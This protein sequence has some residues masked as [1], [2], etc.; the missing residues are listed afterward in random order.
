MKDIQLDYKDA[1]LV[2]VMPKLIVKLE[3]HRSVWASETL[4]KILR[5]LKKWDYILN[6]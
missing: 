3:E 5:L 1:Y 2:E 6:K 4:D